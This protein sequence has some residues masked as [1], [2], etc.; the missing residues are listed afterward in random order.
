MNLKRYL[1]NSLSGPGFNNRVQ[2]IGLECAALTKED[3]ERFLVEFRYAGLKWAYTAGIAGAAIYATLLL[4]SIFRE[5]V[6]PAVD[7]PRASIVVALLLAASI[8]ANFDV[9]QRRV[10]PLLVGFASAIALFGTVFIAF[11]SRNVVSATT[12]SVPVSLTFGLFLHYCFL[13]LPLR[14][15]AFIGW[16]VMGMVLS[17]TP[18]VLAADPVRLSIYLGFTNIFGMVLCHLIES[19]ELDLFLQR[20]ATEAARAE[21]QLRQREAEEAVRQKTRLVASVSHDL[22][23]PMNAASIY[24]DLV[25]HRLGEADMAGALSHAH[26]ARE[27]LTSLGATLDH[28]LSVARYESGKVSIKTEWLR[29]GPVLEGLCES[30]ADEA[31]SRGVEL[32]AFLPLRAVEVRTDRRS[33]ERLISN[34]IS[35]ALK[36]TLQRNGRMGRVLVAVRLHG[37]LA[38]LEVHDTG[39]GIPEVLQERI[40]DPYSQLE[41]AY[42]GRERG[43]GLGLYL[44]RTMVDQLP[45][46]HI[47]LRSV[48]GKGSRFSLSLPGRVALEPS[49]QALEAPPSS[50]QPVESPVW[51]AYVM[52]IEDDRGARESTVALLEELDVIV[53]SGAT[54]TEALEDHGPSERFIDALICDFRL[55]HGV[56]GF[57]A[58][59]TVRET[60][61]YSPWAIV[62]TGEVAVSG[63][64]AHAG[65][66]TVVLQKPVSSELLVRHLSDAVAASQRLHEL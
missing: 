13:R 16:T 7:L 17:L 48:V 66:D 45:Q 41:G 35:N 34:L 52:L 31:A 36:F 23:Q 18:N 46:H 42:L 40:W 55:P 25:R 10:Y 29:I 38:L 53:C 11:I 50:D 9:S 54:A 61:G 5:G 49:V 58:V 37:D 15:S 12:V 28:L 20:R 57:T 39:D 44:V 21:A 3:R 8:V 1:I 63:L 14:V 19:R 56:D 59:K 6:N 65:P 43:L 62:V 27:A 30:Y 32:K 47:A 24:V 2:P 33:L 4:V 22:R 51:G 60:L 26:K 64:L